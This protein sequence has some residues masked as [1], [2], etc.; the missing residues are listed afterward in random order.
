MASQR[1]LARVCQFGLATAQL[2]SSVGLRSSFRS[3]RSSYR[4]FITGKWYNG[5]EA[6][7]AQLRSRHGGVPGPA[8]P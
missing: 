7:A 6:P 5:E 8:W 4:T 2:P 3:M 1:T